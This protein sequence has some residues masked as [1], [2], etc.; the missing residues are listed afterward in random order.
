MLCER[1]LN[2]AC[3]HRMLPPY[4]C[5]AQFHGL[6]HALLD[7][8]SDSPAFGVTALPEMVSARS[9][10]PVGSAR[11]SAASRPSS[12]GSESSYITALPDFRKGGPATVEWPDK[13]RTSSAADYDDDDT[14]SLGGSHTWQ[15]QGPGRTPSLPSRS[16]TAGSA[17]RAAPVGSPL[18][19]SST[20]MP[21]SR[22]AGPRSLR[23][24][25]TTLPE[26]TS[27]QTSGSDAGGTPLLPGTPASSLPPTPTQPSE[28]NGSA[29]LSPGMPRSI[30][31]TGGSRRGLTSSR[32]YMLSSPHSTS[33]DCLAPLP[34]ESLRVPPPTPEIRTPAAAFVEAQNADATSAE[35]GDY[36]GLVSRRALPSHRVVIVQPGVSESHMMSST[37]E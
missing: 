35:N 19:A 20:I 37:D 30:L 10:T 3:Q 24:L 29:N 33:R 28:R 32:R 12:R 34:E 22:S 36:H 1:R 27:S 25:D 9:R 31:V 13:V 7:A 17:S 8:A 21:L 6:L 11:A 18:S 14:S 4:L 23:M 16:W 5:I 15:R 26:Q 2:L